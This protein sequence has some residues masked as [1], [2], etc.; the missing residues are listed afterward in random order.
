MRNTKQAAA[1]LGGVSTSVLAALLLAGCQSTK[2]AAPAAQPEAPTPAAPGATMAAPAAPAPAPAD[3]NKPQPVIR[4]KAGLTEQFKDSAGNAWLPDQGFRDGDT[5]TRPDLKIANTTDPSL[6]MSERY[7]MTS[8]TYPVR[9][10]KYLVKLYFAETYEG[11]TG[12]GQRVFSFTVQ[13]HEF[14]DVDIWVKAGGPL[15]AYVETVPVDVTDG[16]VHITFTP[17]VENPEING[18]EIIPQP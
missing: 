11:I 5:S 4:I 10:G 15:R 9:N 6:Y 18:I 17:N 7:G 3:P 2:E 14:K 12:P 13:G 1:W 16:N 8:F